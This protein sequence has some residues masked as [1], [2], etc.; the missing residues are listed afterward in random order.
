MKKKC[1]CCMVL[2]LA[3]LFAGC[4]GRTTPVEDAIA[5]EMEAK[6]KQPVTEV[7]E[8]QEETIPVKKEPTDVYDFSYVVEEDGKYIYRLT[9][10]ELIEKYDE[11]YAEAF[12]DFIDSLNE[13]LG[14]QNQS[15]DFR[16][17]SHA[18]N[19]LQ[20]KPKK[21]G[22]IPLG[23]TYEMDYNFDLNN[24]GYTYVD[25]DSNGEFELIFGVLDDADAPWVPYGCFER[26][27]AIID[28]TVAK[29]CDGGS[30]DLH[31][32]G[33][34]AKTYETGSG[35]A[36]YSGTWR[37]H[38]EGTY[39]EKG[40]M[41]PWNYRAFVEDGFCGYWE[42]PVLIDEPITDFDKQVKDPKNQVEEAKF[43]DIEEEWIP[44]MVYPEWLRMSD[45]LEKNYPQGI[46]G[47]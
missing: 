22:V 23:S 16:N 27:Y 37:L 24:V 38:F 15:Y 7:E 35:G 5:P 25:L 11:L 31:W 47:L 34:D 8:V 29:I 20:T 44:E 19:L 1:I 13:V 42:V 26:A 41:F 40:D 9:D 2:C 39:V 12:Q 18:S 36:A 3:L 17:R 30:R 46:E 6:D 43:K 4:K 14:Y 33:A 21:D 10:T 45:Y 28:G 32:L